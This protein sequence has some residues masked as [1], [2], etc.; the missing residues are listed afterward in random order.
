M[1]KFL[2]LAYAIDRFNRRIGVVLRWI[3]L[4]MILIG[5]YAAVGRYLTP[6]VGIRLA[7]N[8]LNELQW[9]LFTVIFLM[10]AAYGLERD[11]H[12]RVDILYSRGTA[13]K[14][15]WIDLLGSLFFLIPFCVLML[16]VAWPWVLNSWAQMEVSPDP[17]GLPRYPIKSLILVS[18]ALL[19]LQGVGETIKKIGIIRGHEV[20]D[21]TAEP[22]PEVTF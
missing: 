6:I 2:G 7:P 13:K 11:I 19:L 9:Y 15:A 8:V 18:F 14:R 4:G 3:A 16:V 12:I 17:G 22:K 1:Q 5:A 21:P 10:G 20:N